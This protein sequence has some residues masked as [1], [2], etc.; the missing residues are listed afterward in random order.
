MQYL[1]LTSLFSIV[2]FVL[3]YKQSC[4]FFYHSYSE[5]YIT[6]IIL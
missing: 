3:D 4:K 2:L 6:T 1:F 5:K